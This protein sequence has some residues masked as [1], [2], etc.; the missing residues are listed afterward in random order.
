[1]RGG[2]KREGNAWRV[3]VCVCVCVCACVCGCRLKL[4]I[5]ITYLSTLP[6]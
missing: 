6:D 1:M 3:C 4:I 5:G 2:E